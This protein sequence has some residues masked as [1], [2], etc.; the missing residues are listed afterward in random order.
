M[1]R[2]DITKANIIAKKKNHLSPNQENIKSKDVYIET[3]LIFI[4]F[5]ATN[6]ESL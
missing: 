6:K 3:N 2:T 1:S 5:K 4:D